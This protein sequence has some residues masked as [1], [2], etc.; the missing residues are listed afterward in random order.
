VEVRVKRK[1]VQLR[2]RHGYLERTPEERLSDQLLAALWVGEGNN[3][4]GVRMEP[5]GTAVA[6]E[7]GQRVPQRIGV[8]LSNLTLQQKGAAHEGRFT[9]FVTSRDAQGGRSA[10][11][12]SVVPVSIPADQLEAASRQLFGYEIGLL[13]PEGRQR[14]AIGVRDDL[15]QEVSIITHEIEVGIAA[16][17]QP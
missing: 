2:Y 8:P 11:S 1:G 16:Q 14:V 4:L 15:S 17:R 3:A 9:V 7:G 6:M 13:M 5:A 12:S 10:I